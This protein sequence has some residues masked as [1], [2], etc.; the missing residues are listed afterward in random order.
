MR[1]P[2]KRRPFRI[3]LQYPSG[4]TKT[5]VVKAASRQTAEDRALKRNPNATGIQRQT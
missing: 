1:I 5:V 3:V 4:T 2:A